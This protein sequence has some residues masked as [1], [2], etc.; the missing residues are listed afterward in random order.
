VV[1][2]A[3]YPGPMEDFLL[4]NP[5]LN[6]RFAS[7]VPFTDY[8]RDELEQ[9][10]SN[11]ASSEGYVL[12]DAVRQKASGYLEL[13]RQTEMHF[14]NGRAVRNLFGEMKMLMARR[15]MTQP[16]AS[17]SLDKETLV[18]FST[19]DVPNVDLSETLFNIHRL[20]TK[21]STITPSKNVIDIKPS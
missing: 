3:G 13:L 10:L 20:S 17:A 19:E 15:L 5:G 2:V 18:T 14:G 12:P 11:L 7:R 16:D 21:D 4:S 6:S 8:S 9:I 1:I